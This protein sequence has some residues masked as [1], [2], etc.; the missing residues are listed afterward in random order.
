M[1]EGEKQ[2]DAG[3]EV[4]FRLVADMQSAQ[5]QGM[6]A[7][8]AIRDEIERGGFT[9]RPTADM[10]AI[11]ESADK[12]KFAFT[13]IGKAEDLQAGLRNVQAQLEKIVETSGKIDMSFGGQTTRLSGKSDIAQFI[14]RL[15]EYAGVTTKAGEDVRLGISGIT[16]N[17][18][19]SLLAAKGVRE[20]AD[21]TKKAKTY[22]DDFLM[23]LGQGRVQRAVSTL[24][25]GSMTP[26]LGQTAGGI[27]GGATGLILGGALYTLG[28]QLAGM[29]EK[30]P[31]KIGE[32]IQT[33]RHY[34]VMR[35]SAGLP[36]A[37]ELPE[38]PAATSEMKKQLYAT[39]AWKD[40][41]AR[42]ND[43]WRH[44]GVNNLLWGK[45]EGDI[46][47]ERYENMTSRLSMEI[48]QEDLK[49]P[50][51]HRARIDKIDQIVMQSML[52]ETENPQSALKAESAAWAWFRMM[53][54][55]EK[56]GGTA[57][58]ELMNSTFGR[59][60]L[61]EANMK[62][63]IFA[64][65]PREQQENIIAMQLKESA[66]LFGG[67][68]NPNAWTAEKLDQLLRSH[69][70]TEQVQKL[71]KQHQREINLG[72]AIHEY[73][74]LGNLLADAGQRPVAER[75]FLRTMQEITTGEG[76][77]LPAWHFSK[78][79]RAQG[80]LLNYREAFQLPDDNLTPDQLRIRGELRKS[81]ME[82]QG[83]TGDIEKDLWKITDWASTLTKLPIERATE[84]IK[85]VSAH[86]TG[87]L[88][89]LKTIFGIGGEMPS[90]PLIG[91]PR[92]WFESGEGLVH[93]MQTMGGMQ[94]DMAPGARLTTDQTKAAIE[95]ATQGAPD[96]AAATAQH[97]ADMSTKLDTLITLVGGGKP[98]KT[99]EGSHSAGTT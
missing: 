27:L 85:S 16:Q 94:I 32:E 86:P 5:A 64:M 37:S 21:T 22:F 76:V 58:N 78:T 38:M 30:I 51:R 57:R 97:T 52:R 24:A 84:L 11:Q 62:N 67:V 74:I 49:N 39:Q 61:T 6:R 92:F 73:P 28:Y 55:I 95:A 77:S 75:N 93:K 66:T 7:A 3:L 40:N 56:G 25:T 89:Q 79:G 69:V 65:E 18:K 54:P 83:V 59:R 4:L 10:K 96:S 80:H 19:E 99:Q 15:P 8:T 1:A 23:Y 53:L 31:E 81:M 63:A 36:P 26:L 98:L 82:K 34:D 48:P 43:F 20:F 9:I 68:P 12:F 35:A 60:L 2:I 44:Q 42:A 90:P 41:L 45:G 88:E 17:D 13:A 29:F 46:L 91:Q 14:Q 70:P 47:A 71:I 87:S 33:F 72:A 50:E